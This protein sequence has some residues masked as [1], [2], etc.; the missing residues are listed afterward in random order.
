MLFV[1]PVAKN[2]RHEIESA[3]GARGLERRNE[4]RSDVPAITHVDYSARLQT[5]DP[6][7]HGLFYRLVQRFHALTG[8]PLVVNTSFNVRGEPIVG[9]IDDA[10]RCFLATNIDCL[11]LENCVVLKSEQRNPITVDAAAY[12]NQFELD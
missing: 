12:L 3:S 7:R 10:F 9:S 11:V 2:R 1:A 8:C 4:V 5:I 6:A